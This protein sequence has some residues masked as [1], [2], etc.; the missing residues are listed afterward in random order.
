MTTL[1]RLSCSAKSTWCPA[2]Q[3]ASLVGCAA[4]TD[5]IGDDYVPRSNLSI[6]DI[7]LE[8]CTSSEMRLLGSVSVKGTITCFGWGCKGV[9]DGSYSK[10]ILATGLD[11]NSFYLWNAE[12]IVRG[13]GEGALLAST[14]TSSSLTVLAFHPN[15][16]NALATGTREGQ[17]LIWDLSRVDQPRSTVAPQQT[18]GAIACFAWNRRAP[19]LFATASEQGDTNIWDMRQKS[20]LRTVAPAGRIALRPSALSWDDEVHYA[21]SHYG[22]PSVEIWDLRKPT[23]YVA[24]LNH[25]SS[26]AAQAQTYGMPPQTSVI[27]SSFCPQDRNLFVTVGDDATTALWRADTGVLLSITSTPECA[28]WNWSP[29][30]PGLALCSSA[31]SVTVSS[32]TNM[33]SYVPAWTPRRAGVTFGFGGKL[34]AFGQDSRI[35]PPPASNPNS[36]MTSPN[37]A[38]PPAASQWSPIPHVPNPYLILHTLPVDEQAQADAL[39]FYQVAVQNGYATFTENMANNAAN[40]AATAPQSPSQ[41]ET[42]PSLEAAE[43]KQWKLIS[44]LYQTP[45]AGLA[46]AFLSEL[47]FNGVDESALQNLENPTAALDTALKAAEEEYA[48]NEAAANAR[49]Q[50]ELARID[51]ELQSKLAELEGAP[52]AN[53]QAD[54]DFD[55]MLS[56]GGDLFSML[57]SGPGDASSATNGQDQADAERTK[58][59]AIEDAKARAQSERDRVNRALSDQLKAA[60]ATLEKTR[61]ELKQQN[62]AAA[63]DIAAKIKSGSLVTAPPVNVAAD[64]PI[65]DAIISGKLELASKLCLAANRP[66]DALLLAACAGEQVWHQIRAQYLSSHRQPFFSKA[67]P[68]I[69][70]GDHKG[71]VANSDLKE[72]RQTL[73]TLICS[74]FENHYDT[75]AALASALGDRL[76]AAAQ[77]IKAG[78]SP[79][80]VGVH[81]ETSAALDA[82]VCYL[83]ASDCDKIIQLWTRFPSLTQAALNKRL[84]ENRSDVISP[85]SYTHE[86]KDA[87]PS[88]SSTVSLALRSVGGSSTGTVLP[89]LLVEKA[90]ALAVGFHQSCGSVPPSPSLMKL[91]ADYIGRLVA[92]GLADLAYGFLSLAQMFAPPASSQQSEDPLVVMRDLLVNSRPNAEQLKQELAQHGQPLRTPWTP[93]DVAQ[94]PQWLQYQGQRQQQQQQQQALQQQYMQQAQP[95][96]V[97]PAAV[98]QAARFGPQAVAP[99]QPAQPAVVAGSNYYAAAPQAQ[100]A[101]VA[102]P[103][104]PMPAQPTYAAPVAPVQPQPQPQPQPQSTRP[105]VNV[106]QLA[107]PTQPVPAQPMY[108]PPTVPQPTVPTTAVPSVP[109]PAPVPTPAPARPAPMTTPLPAQ[110]VQPQQPSMPAP[111]APVPSVPTPQAPAQ[112]TPTAAQNVNVVDEQQVQFIV[113]SLKALSAAVDAAVANTP[114]AKKTA[115]RQKGLDQL[116]SRLSTPEINAEA[117]QVLV[118]IVQALQARDHSTAYT[119]CGTLGDL[120]GGSQTYWVACLKSLIVAARNANISL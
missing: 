20:A 34:V 29:H 61:A 41:Q 22:S 13:Q 118:T 105:A 110:P 74:Y 24:R 68:F 35:H 102:P 80:S 58:Q 114:E 23:N 52:A 39:N 62:E 27:H 38:K 51:A 55:A 17:L 117:R 99:T 19:H 83:A 30:Q 15:E 92:L 16:Q 56:G 69:L 47:Q 119:R 81:S 42:N 25:P 45:R 49:A 93:V 33:G 5:I 53:A 106:P 71:L 88:A 37:A 64:I 95:Q 72:W 104:R 59:Q 18:R 2:K 96:A 98:A 1:K 82:F 73:A 46:N 66:A 6:Y 76:A 94:D 116:Y 21:T 32:M 89:L 100:P 84:K 85:A 86:S 10:G 54:F 77:A 48:A 9:E 3:H 101:P 31:A 50:A 97:A 43:A 4:S 40:L 112:Q 36:P 79:A 60:R 87:S 11:N 14:E 26:L 120:V 44:L 91:Y 109:A 115:M 108:Q 28:E 113:Q 65:R 111:V 63:S 67:V 57:G 90:T 103:A 70:Q 7:A 12:G 78:A 107:Q 75:F 8:D